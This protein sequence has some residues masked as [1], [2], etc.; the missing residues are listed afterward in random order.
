M[1]PVATRRSVL[2]VPLSALFASV[3][4]TAHAKNRPA[5]LSPLERQRLSSGELV[6]RPLEFSQEG[7]RYIGGLAYQLVKA[8]PGLV[9]R[10]LSDVRQ[11]PNALPNTH[12]AQLLDHVDQVRR[13]EL[14]QGN[15]L[16]LARFTVDVVVDERE[17]SFRFWMAPERPHDISDVWGYFRAEHFGGQCLLTLG[18][19]L[20]LKPGLFASLFDTRIQRAMLQMPSHLK[21]YLEAPGNREALA[22][23]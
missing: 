11:L 2:M 20:S 1:L 19:A 13:I 14:V 7:R 15:A 8:P 6:E 12:E 17:R 22:R 23:R 3:A 16:L 21:R 10:T 9:T 5:S 18:V 4:P